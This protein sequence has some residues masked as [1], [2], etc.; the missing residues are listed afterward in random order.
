MLPIELE[1]GNDDQSSQTCPYNI[2]VFAW[3]FA[4]GKFTPNH[5]VYC[6]QSNVAIV[7][8]MGIIMNPI[9]WTT[10]DELAF[11]KR[12]GGWRNNRKTV[13]PLVR[14]FF[15]EHYR[16][17]MLTRTEWEK[18]NEDKSVVTRINKT[19]IENYIR[20]ELIKLEDKLA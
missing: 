13:D 2:R 3:V 4:W 7:G 9:I 16:D 1:R 11:L 5:S 18:S 12:T 20:T 14:L 10:D 6:I 8:N 19:I 17:S 15:L